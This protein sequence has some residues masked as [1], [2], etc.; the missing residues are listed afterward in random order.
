[1]TKEEIDQQLDEM[2]AEAATKADGGLKPGL[3]YLNANLYGTEVRTETL[4][5]KRGQRYRGL[6][7][8]VARAYE[9]EIITRAEVEKR[10]LEVGE[11]EDL[12]LAPARVAIA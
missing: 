5:A 2:T 9:T 8:F 12:E 6:R 3:L 11:Y 1:M 10:G 4:S 7:V